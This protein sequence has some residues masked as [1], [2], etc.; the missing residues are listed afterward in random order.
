MLPKQ[1]ALVLGGGGVAGIA[2]EIGL[3]AG[4]ADA[5]IDVRNA[6]LFVGTS[7]GSVV[8]ALITSGVALEASFQQQ[9]DPHLQV[10]ELMPRFDVDS[11]TSGLARLAEGNPGVTEILRRVGA[12]A[13]VAP[14]VSE[15]ER[16]AV[17]AS[18]LPVQTWPEAN[19][20][21]VVVDTESGERRVFDRKSGVGLVD[22]VGSSCAVPLVFPPVTIAGRRYM[23]GGIFSAEN[24]D[25]AT[26]AERVL[27]L[28]LRPRQPSLSV[29]PLQA[30]LEPVR[31][32]GARIVVV[33]PDQATE[34]V[35]ASVGWNLLDPS[36]RE[37]SA[38]AGREQGRSVAAHEVAPLWQ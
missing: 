38:R 10:K 6:D 1:R 30:G 17:I 26:G 29:V 23:D 21:I 31:A 18:R 33:H 36:I 11:F 2:W 5:G 25:L 12:L 27:I 22:A 24:A 15:P 16:R 37:Q 9:V 35:F 28:T 20:L 14:T 34:A 8:A 4:L 3:I 7:A 32:A 13:L 19:L